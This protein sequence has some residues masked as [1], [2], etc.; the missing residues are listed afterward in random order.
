MKIKLI[1][2]NI[3]NGGTLFENIKDFCQKEQADIYLFQEV[4]NSI[5]PDLPIQ[6]RSFQK[7]QSFINHPYNHFAPT[8]IEDVNGTEVVSGNVI[9]SKFKLTEI[10]VTHY[11]VPFG[12]RKYG[13][14]FFQDSPRS[15]QHAV[16]HIDGTELHL[17]N[18]QGIWGEDGGDSPR[19]VAMASKIVAEIGNHHPLILAGDFNVQPNTETIGLIENKLKNVFKNELKTTFNVQRKDLVNYPGY[20]DAVV[21]MLFITPD[22]KM[23][24]HRCPPVDI[25]DHY[26]L[27]VTFEI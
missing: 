8:F 19:R 23:L 22:I 16:A 6:Y 3:W 11:D 5:N 20:A 2:L 21:D 9:F 27:I 26:P 4:Y 13:R 10:S 1:C 25:S 7:L 24:E 15:L 18:T 17:L 12:K 14:E